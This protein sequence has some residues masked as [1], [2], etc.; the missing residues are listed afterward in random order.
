MICAYRSVTGPSNP[1][2]M[3]GSS[4]IDDRYAI[5]ARTRSRIATVSVSTSSYSV[6]M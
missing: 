1:Q 4:P 6:L 3:S 2:V 5:Q